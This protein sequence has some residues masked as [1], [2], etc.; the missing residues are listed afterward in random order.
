[1]VGIY[2]QLQFC[3]MLGD[4]AKRMQQ[5]VGRPRSDVAQDVV[6]I[7]LHRLYLQHNAQ[8][9]GDLERRLSTQVN[10]V[11]SHDS[12]TL[13]LSCFGRYGTHTVHSCNAECMPVYAGSGLRARCLHTAVGITSVLVML[14]LHTTPLSRLGVRQSAEAQGVNR[15]VA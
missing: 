10:C 14:V 13:L 4:V 2:R 1:M 8:H 12:N 6:R 7:R 15:T 11:G 5:L 3:L 9:Y